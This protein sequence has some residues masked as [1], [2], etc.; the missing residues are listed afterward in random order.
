MKQ[1]ICLT[2][3]LRPRDR[4]GGGT[5]GTTP[6]RTAWLCCH[7]H[8]GCANWGRGGHHAANIFKSAR[9]VANWQPCCKRVGNSIL[10]DL[11]LATIA[12][13]LV[14][15]HP[16]PQQKFYRNITH[17]SILLEVPQPNSNPFLILFGRTRKLILVRTGG[18]CSPPPP[19]GVDTTQT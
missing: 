13:Q 11:F 19:R 14:K 12:G 8:Q 5:F 9:K 10:C 16:P 1:D 4:L 17:L 18:T 3:Q 7:I 6:I 15:R 2:K